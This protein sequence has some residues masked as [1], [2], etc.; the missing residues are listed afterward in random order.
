MVR[1][2]ICKSD[3]PPPGNIREVMLLKNAGAH[4]SSYLRGYA[5]V[6]GKNQYLTGLFH[7]FKTGRCENGVDCL[8]LSAN[9]VWPLKAPPIAFLTWQQ[10]PPSVKKTNEYTRET[11]NH[12]ARYFNLGLIA[13]RCNH[14]GITFLTQTLDTISTLVH[15]YVWVTYFK[16]PYTHGKFTFFI[17]EAKN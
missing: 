14:F 9:S 13:P 7:H 11:K 10:W 17:I 5:R 16:Y 6:G 1:V 3:T 4:I 12:C 2:R 15:Q 8:R